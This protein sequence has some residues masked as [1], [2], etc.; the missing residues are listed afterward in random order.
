[1]LKLLKETGE[2]GRCEG[3]KSA[4]CWLREREDEIFIEVY[5]VMEDSG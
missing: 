4:S 3:M 2:R 5:F 1:M